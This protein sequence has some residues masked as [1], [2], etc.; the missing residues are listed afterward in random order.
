MFRSLLA[1]VEAARRGEGLFF[2]ALLPEERIDGCV[3]AAR[4]VWD[5]WI[6]TPA[7]TVWTFLAQCLSAD[8]S[9]VEAVARLVVW[10][11]GRGMR[12]CSAD[13]SAYCTARDHL[14][15][16]ACHELVVGTGRDLEAEAPEEWLWHGRRVRVAD[17]T[18]ATMP[19]TPANQAEYP[20]QST[21][22]PGCGFP[23]CRIVVVFS[24]AVGS[25]LDAAIAPYRGKRTGENSLLRDMTDALDPGDVLLVDRAYGGWCDVALLIERGLD[26][27]V[28]QHQSRRTDFRR[29]RRLGPDDHVVTW[30]RP[31]RP[32]GIDRETYERLPERLEMREIRIRV[33]Q[34]DFRTDT[35]VVATTLLDAD[36][37]P[38]E[39]IADLYRQRWHAELDLRNLETVLAMEHLR[40]RAPH[41][42]R[43]E[44]RMHLLAHNLIRRVM[45][46]A[47]RQADLPPRWISFKAAL[48]TL[49][50]FL[51][52]IAHSAVPADTWLHEL[53]RAVATHVVGQRP[54][55][56]EPRRVKKRQKP[57]K[58]MTKPRHEYQHHGHQGG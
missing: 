12:A 21:Q 32:E 29:G 23:I 17:G 1:S 49:G 56:R 7:V 25:V 40:C 39:E 18:T 52:A 27:V 6:Y 45:A 9:C 13:T 33:E 16:A 3:R 34:P 42:V 44:I 35:L 41:R 55:R 22:A 57:F 58:L 14:P 43:N 15:E 48:R 30:T 20:Q 47:A 2:G 36:E 38:R 11:V 4:E 51:P 24:L 5:G 10:R 54:D 8:H 46:T 50:Q 28:R 53:L 37:Y 31:A 19:D 26:V